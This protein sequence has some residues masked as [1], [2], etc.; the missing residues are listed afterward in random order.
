[1]R[2]ICLGNTGIALAFLAAARDYR[3][4]LVM[5]ASTSIERRKV[6][7][8]LGAG[9][10]L[11]PAAL[12]MRGGSGEGRDLVRTTRNA[13]MLQ[14][15][16]HLANPDIHRRTTVEEIWNDTHGDIDFFVAGVGTGV[17]ITGDGQVLKHATGVEPQV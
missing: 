13:V 11:T 5:P 6:L 10:V 4:I 3:L 14:Q 8:L 17:T 12:G 9:I 1:M 15:F 16:K 2:L 7:T